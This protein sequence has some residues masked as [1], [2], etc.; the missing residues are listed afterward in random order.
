MLDCDDVDGFADRIVDV[1][2]NADLASE[3]RRK[4]MSQAAKFRWPRTARE[5]LRLYT[6]LGEA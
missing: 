1:M 3:M 6:E 5:T 4:G 2:T